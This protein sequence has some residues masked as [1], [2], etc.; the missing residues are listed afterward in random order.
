MDQTSLFTAALGLQSPWEVV[1][2]RFLEQERRIDFD[3]AFVAGTRFVCP[4]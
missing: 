3:I 1:D 4:K 2:V